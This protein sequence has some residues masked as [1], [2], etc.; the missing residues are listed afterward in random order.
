MKKYIFF[1]FAS[2]LALLGQRCTADELPQP[3]GCAPGLA[4]YDTNMKE[5]IDESCAYSGC[6]DGESPG[7]PGNYTSYEGIR[8][9]LE[10]GSVRTRVIDLRNDPVLG[11]PPSASVYP[12]SR[13]ENLSEEEFELMQC[14]LSSGFPKE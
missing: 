3:E 1:L 13:M 11:M 4:T 2:L 8:P 9:F 5:I 7:V 10:D 6:H 14:W 12:Q